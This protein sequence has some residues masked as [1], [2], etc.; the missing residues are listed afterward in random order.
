MQTENL[1]RASAKPALALW[2]YSLR[3][4]HHIFAK[5]GVVSP[6]QQRILD[7]VANGVTS[8]SDLRENVFKRN[9]PITLI[10]AD[11]DALA[12]KNLVSMCEDENGVEMW[13]LG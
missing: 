4:V 10:R 8:I 13:T 9:R 7:E 12:K 11:L 1:E 6:E 2:D 3:S 5:H